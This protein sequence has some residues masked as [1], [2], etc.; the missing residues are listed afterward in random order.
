[1]GE[2]KLQPERREAAQAA[3]RSG[4]RLAASLRACYH[5]LTHVIQESGVCL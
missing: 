2:P 5:H 4:Q 1:M 3:H